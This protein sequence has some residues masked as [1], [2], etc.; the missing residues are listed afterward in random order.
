MEEAIEIAKL[1]LF[2]ALVASAN[3]VDDLEP[4]PNI[5]FN[6]MTGNSLIGLLQVDEKDFDKYAQDLA[7]EAMFKDYRES[8]RRR[9]T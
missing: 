2:L 6:I 3:S 9:M 4:L 5:E 7:T 8:W 1:R